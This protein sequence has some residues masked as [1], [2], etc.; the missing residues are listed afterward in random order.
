MC[1]L[2]IV[3]DDSS[4][5]MNVAA[6]ANAGMRLKCVIDPNLGDVNGKTAS[7]PIV[8]G[9]KAGR[10][11][12]SAGADSAAAAAKDFHAPDTEPQIQRKCSVSTSAASHATVFL[13]I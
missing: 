6:R 5:G 12:V 9:A 3:S 4:I 7:L 11:Q 2:H 13:R 10:K 8:L 1:D